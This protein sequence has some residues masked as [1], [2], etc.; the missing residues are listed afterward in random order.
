M[1]LK[2]TVRLATFVGLATTML[3][4]A[5]VVALP[6]SAPTLDAD[7]HE[8]GY[9]VYHGPDCPNAYPNCAEDPTDEKFLS[10][11]IYDYRNEHWY[12]KPT[13]LIHCFGDSLE[14]TLDIGMGSTEY[15]VG[16]TIGSYETAWF[17]MS[18]PPGVTTDEVRFGP[19]DT[20]RVIKIIHDADRR[21]EGL[22]IQVYDD[23]GIS[24]PTDTL[25]LDP[26]GFAHNLPRLPCHGAP[27][28]WRG[29]IVA[30]EERC[31]PYNANDYSYP[32]SLKAELVEMWGGHA[33]SLYTGRQYNSPDD[34]DMDHMVGLP[35]AHDSGLCASHPMLRAQ[36]AS[37]PINLMLAPPEVTRTQKADKDAADWLPESNRCW[38]ANSVVTV[39]QKYHLTIDQRE[40][41]ALEAVISACRSFEY[42]YVV[43]HP[44]DQPRP[45]F[46]DIDVP[47]P[48]RFRIGRP[49]H[50]GA[51]FTRAVTGFM[52]DAVFVTNGY[53]SN[54]APSESVSYNYS[55]RFDFTPT[56]I[57]E[58]SVRV[59]HGEAHTI[60]YLGPPYDDDNNGRI[61]WPELVESARD[62][63][64]GDLAWPHA[65]ALAQ[66][67]L[68][69]THF[70]R[71]L[72]T[73]IEVKVGVVET[74]S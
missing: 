14:F 54:F 9:W 52:E 18:L 25:S 72:R 35:E 41:D 69:D 15:R 21:D 8:G 60:V 58:V 29:L 6:V 56:S 4:S 16:L 48:W 49:V 55:Y 73:D 37:D 40:A 47:I 65:L 57:G 27:S 62:V 28:T 26:G 59:K 63:M 11:P 46:V 34:T 61:D 24:T 32:Q 5:L 50:M 33:V 10:L 31:S 71:T 51:F 36:F 38:F 44:P 53:V 19:D 22:L 68:S 70:H 45:L 1:I 12:D 20:A 17:H 67:Y 3:L 43:P 30:P 2:R 42:A 64:R 13:I 39:R 23:S 7:E 66:L 74:E